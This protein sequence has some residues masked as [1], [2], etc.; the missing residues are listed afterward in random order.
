M[1]P[2]LNH[3]FTQKESG[4]LT[5]GVR[6]LLL[7]P[8]NALANDQLK[9]LRNLLCNYPEI[10]FGSYTGETEEHEKDALEKYRKMYKGEKPLGNELI[11]REKMKEQPPHILITNYA[12]LEYL[13]LRPDDNVFFDGPYAKDWR[14][15]VLDEV[16]TYT[17]AK[18]IEMSMLL[19]RLK[20]RVLIDKSQQLKFVGTSATIGRGK[21][22]FKDVAKF[23]EKLFGEKVCWN[24]S[25]KKKQDIIHGERLP[26]EISKESWGKPDIHLYEKWCSIIETSG[27]TDIIQNLSKIS[28]NHHVPLQI[29][30]RAMET[31]KNDGYHRF[32]YEILKGDGEL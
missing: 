7:Y 13:L 14:F 16:H 30:N 2:I 23:G 20:E 11:S 25:E 29:I 22:D 31:S 19:R 6:A 1:I 3:L 27:N 8:M 24:D 12:M 5:P 17:G 9:R 18:G 26:I 15:I 10:T 4:K 32:I 28:R 21:K